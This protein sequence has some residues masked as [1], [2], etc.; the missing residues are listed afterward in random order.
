M[1]IKNGSLPEADDVMNAFGSIFNDVA[2]NLFNADYIG[3]DSRLFSTGVPNLKNIFY[4]TFT[5]DD[6]DVNYGFQYSSGDDLYALP[7]LDSVSYYCIIEATAYT[8]SDTTNIIPIATGKWLIFDSTLDASAEVQRA[9]VMKH[10]LQTGELGKFTT[11]TAW[12]LSDSDDVGYRGYR[13]SVSEQVPNGC[14]YSRTETGTFGTTTGNTISSWSNVASTVSAITWSLPVGTSLNSGTVDEIGTDTSADET[15]NPANC[16]FFWSGNNATGSSKTQSGIVII[17]A[18]GTLTWVGDF[19]TSAAVDYY[20]DDSV[21]ETTL[22][23][24]LSAEGAEVATLVFKDTASASV[25]NAI[26]VI[27]STI[28]A[29]SS[30]VIS[31]SAD[32]GSNWTD[33]NNAEIARPTAGTAL[34]R[35]IVITRTDLSK[36]DNVTEQAVKYELY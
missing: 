21:P 11:I 15:L 31:V 35:K 13:G 2:Q 28:D 27:N 20:T 12:K 29:T 22:A 19:G 24:S 30:Q 8:G 1:A 7:D 25:T 33:V 17:L 6:A 32:G 18:K 4:S 23:G 9:Q 5:S 3:F 10:L 36:L 16:S 34:W 26:P 14:N